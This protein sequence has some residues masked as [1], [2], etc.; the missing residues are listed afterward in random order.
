MD[1]TATA[2]NASISSTSGNN[3]TGVIGGTLAPFVVQ[4]AGAALTSAK[5]LSQV[6]VTWTVTWRR[7]TFV[8]HYFDRCQR[9]GHEYA[10]AGSAGGDNTVTATIPGTGAVKATF[11][12]TAISL[13]SASIASLSGNGQTA[14][15]GNPLQPFVVQV[16]SNGQG[17]Q[18]ISVNW[19]AVQGGGT[20]KTATSVTDANGN[21]SD[22]LT[23]GNRAR[24][25]HRACIDSESG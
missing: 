5:G 11:N 19:T 17:I 10:Y 12:A 20:L 7:H 1:F 14:A 23:L 4:I 8:D 16:L 22:T 3:Q 9:Q 13:A 24:R 18:G 2:S 21:A 15:V 25:Q 6:L